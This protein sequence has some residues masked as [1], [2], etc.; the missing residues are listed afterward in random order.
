MTFITQAIQG[1]MFPDYE[2]TIVDNSGGISLTSV[3]SDALDFSNQADWAG[4]N[5]FL[6]NI[7]ACF[8]A[9]SFCAFLDSDRALNV[10]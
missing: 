6:P 4:D 9:S 8:S 5:I 3:L 1:G 2:V 10:S 7:L